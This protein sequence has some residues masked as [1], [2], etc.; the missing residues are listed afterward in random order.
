MNYKDDIVFE[1]KMGDGSQPNQGLF[2]KLLDVGKRALTGESIFMTHFT[3]R[4]WARRGLDLR[5]LTR[6]KLF[7]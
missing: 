2:G 4:E 5:L 3:S 6:A 7:V 1:A